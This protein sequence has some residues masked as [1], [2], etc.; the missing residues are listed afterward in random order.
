MPLNVLPRPSQLKQALLCNL[1]EVIMKRE[2]ERRRW[3]RRTYPTWEVGIVYPQYDERGQQA[4]SRDSPDT[5]LVLL[6]NQSE[7]GF[8]LKSPLR[9]KP[10]SFLHMNLR[11]CHERGWM[12]LFGRVVCSAESLTD[13]KYFSWV[14]KLIRKGSV[15]TPLPMGH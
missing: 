15:K 8:L 5:L 2:K 11:L 9:F 6:M 12:P 13:A 4:G 1:M 3:P 7:N 10:G 14:L